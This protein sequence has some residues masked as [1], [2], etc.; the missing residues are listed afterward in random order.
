VGEIVGSVLDPTGAVIPDA[1]VTAVQ[2][3]TGFS[4]ST[5]SSG[6]GTYTLAALP[7]GTY[8]VRA[9]HS[10]FST[11]SVDATLD[12]NQQREVNFTLAVAGTT[13]QVQ[14]SAAPPLLT[15]T[16]G[17]LGGLV[18]GQQVVALPLNGRTIENLMMLQPGVQNVPNTQGFHNLV[19]PYV[20]GNGNRGPSGASF[21]DDAETTDDMNGGYLLTNFN[22]DALAEF[23]VLQN[24]YSAQYG[25]GAGYIVLLASKSGTNDFHGS[26][27]EFL[28]N[29]ALDSRN[30]FS[31][32]VPPFKRNEFGGAIG[33]PITIPH[34]YDGKDRSFFFFQYAGFR[35][36]RGEPQVFAVPTLDER[37]GIVDTVGKNGQPD[38]LL[39]PLNSVA[40]AMANRY[41][42]PNA[43]NG[44]F[45]PRT[46]EGNI[47]APLN[48]DQWSGRIDHR[49]SDKDS[50][51]GRFTTS[52]NFMPVLEPVLALED[53]SF[54][55]RLE[56]DPT[57]V[58]INYT[59]VISPTLLNSLRFSGIRTNI[60]N[61]PGT[62]TTTSST[63]ADGS[64]ADWGPASFTSVLHPES[65]HF[66]DSLSWTKGRHSIST[67]FEFVRV[68]LNQHAASVGGFQGQYVFRPGIPLPVAIPSASGNNNL[69]AGDPSP[70]GLISFLVGDPSFYNRTLA[71]PGFGPS[72]GGFAPFGLRRFEL[73][74]YVQ[75]D[76]SATRKLTLNFG[77]RYEYNSVVHEV[78]GRLAG[79]VDDPNLLG[80]KVYRMLVLNPD[81]V[82]FPD[83]RGFGPR[84]GLAYKLD[85]KTVLRGGYGIFTNKP[86][87]VRYN[88][89]AV[90]FPFAA[91]GT[92]INPTFSLTPLSVAGLPVL[93]DLRGNPLPPGGDT[94]KVPPNTPVNL[95][96]VANFFGG[97]LETNI[98]S[99]NWRNGYTM[100]GNVTLERELPG[101][102]V[103]QLAYVSNNAAKLYA[104]EYPNAYTGALPQYTPFTLA[105]PGLG[106]FHQRW[107][108]ELSSSTFL[109][110]MRS[111]FPDQSWDRPTSVFPRTP[112]SRNGKFSLR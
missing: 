85:D 41:P 109:T 27:F 1:K 65:Y 69:T 54:T 83:R 52:H 12:V 22:L 50:I 42:A 19:A 60:R 100:A 40:Q 34:V 80:G 5:V 51:F 93:T 46:F 103:M 78:A 92:T 11:G 102:V 111:I 91:F 7:V 4:R 38:Q 67:G 70:S 33:G 55:G 59:H 107:S 26:A 104:A 97:P 44:P 28:R 68:R 61:A 87:G 32:G 88:Q 3:E 77:L 49:F 17:T 36:E 74:G 47:N 48:R 96:P 21:L 25:H 94:K 6:A 20:T 86:L 82:Y 110:S 99:M 108:L 30:F 75:D 53:P 71:F 112:C 35:Q 62:F 73:A 90:G 79:I 56:D 24:N 8:T 9:E 29:S 64:L 10:G 15:T 98:I 105:D 31:S 84:F 58:G 13:A 23:K 63:F 76:V 45:G 16:N 95:I 2:K 37:K 72:G 14:V 43:P 101:N 39:V 57:N 81:P 18:N 106:E 66:Q 89:G